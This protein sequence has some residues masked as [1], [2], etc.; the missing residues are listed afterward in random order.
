MIK[1]VMFFM[2]P[3]YRWKTLK[4]ALETMNLRSKREILDKKKEFESRFLLSEKMG[5]AK[6]ME[7]YFNYITMLKWVCEEKIDDRA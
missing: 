2:A 3:Y 7:K 1:L 4:D 6:D 5:R